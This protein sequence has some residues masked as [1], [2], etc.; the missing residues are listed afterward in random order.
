MRGEAETVYTLCIWYSRVVHGLVI[1]IVVSVSHLFVLVIFVCGIV[2]ASPS[3][4]Q[5]RTEIRNSG[6][7]GSYFTISLAT[8]MIEG[9]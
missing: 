7:T 8:N 4:A 6:L 5:Q 9:R 3:E 1:I 2:L